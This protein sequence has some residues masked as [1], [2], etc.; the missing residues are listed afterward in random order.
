MTREKEKL[1]LLLR[2]GLS[3]AIITALAFLGMLSSAII[4][5][6]TE[7]EAAAINQAGT[8]RMQSYR[9]ASSLAIASNSLEQPADWQTF[10]ALINEFNTRLQSPRLTGI[11]HRNPNSETGQAYRGIEQKWTNKV[12]PTLLEWIPEGIGIQLSPPL[13]DHSAQIKKSNYMHIID[14]FVDDIDY[15]VGLLE[16]KTEARIQFLRLIQ[17]VSLFMTLIVAFF[18]MYLVHTDVLSPLREL[19]NFTR[20]VGQRDFSHRVKHTASDELG[21][22]GQAFN[23]MAEDLSIQY[24]DLENLVHEKTSDLE[25]SNRSLEL[26]YNTTRTINTDTPTESTYKELLNDIET[27]LGA[28][29]GTICLADPIDVEKFEFGKRGAYKLAT[30]RNPDNGDLG[31]CTP[32]NCAACFGKCDTH[33]IDLASSD[34]SK[35]N[36]ISIPILDQELQYGVLLIEINPGRVLEEWQTKL[37]EAIASHIGMA[38]T[39]AKSTEQD[40]RIALLEE[41]SVIARELHDSLAQSLSYMKIQVSRLEHGIDNSGDLAQGRQIVNELR[42]GLN[43]AY[44]ELR[45]LLTTFRLNIVDQDLSVALEET[46]HEFAERSSVSIDLHNN[47]GGCQL[48]ANEDINLLQIVREALSNVVQHSQASHANITLNHDAYGYVTVQIDDNGI[49]ISDSAKKHHYGLT[50][51]KER[52]RSLGGSIRIISRP[53]GGSRVELIFTPSHRSKPEE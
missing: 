50:I 26:L 42:Q 10:I 14:D 6:T 36:V 5:E 11:L 53:E 2:L 34:L 28:S 27:M 7:G 43:S 9:I 23:T 1:T 35:Q 30:S 41:R 39:I 17:V 46:T 22:L 47:L 3:M 12:R 8:L 31:T 32:P 52:A 19:L 16:K 15:F 29:S 49:G 4:A 24:D 38:L 37:L 20:H 40:R 13:N 44:R 25:R 51:M 48:S 45:E 21:Q 33:L 18:T